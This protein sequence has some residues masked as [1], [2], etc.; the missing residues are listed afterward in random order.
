MHGNIVAQ[1]TMQVLEKEG[2]NLIF[3]ISGTGYLFVTKLK[4]A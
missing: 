4:K 2:L 3:I 1:E